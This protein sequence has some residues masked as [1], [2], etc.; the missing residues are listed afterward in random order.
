M[1]I[2]HPLD[3]ST[4]HGPQNHRAHLE[5]LVKY[6][7]IGIKEGAKL[8]CGGKQ[9]PMPG[10]YFEPTIFTE[11]TDDMY[12]AKEESFGPIMIISSFDDIYSNDDVE[13]LIRRAN[14][15]EYGLASGV[16][17]KDMSKALL[18]A[19]KICSGTCFINC[20]N[21]TDVAAPFGGF[22]QSGVGKDLGREALNEYLKTKTVTVEY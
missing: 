16:L 4:D 21:K 3:R 20:Y 11:V 2:G 14:A 1:K 17:T 18:V 22:K 7:E 8:V 6:A 13:Q 15:T 12:I 9:A 5:K 19:E 10:L